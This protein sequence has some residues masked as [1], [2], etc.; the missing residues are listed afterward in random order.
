MQPILLALPTILSTAKEVFG[1][2]RELYTYVN[3]L[4]SAAQQDA[5]WTEAQDAHWQQQI[6]D[7]GLEPHW[8]PRN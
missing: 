3:K 5:E 2:G 8:Q 6:R 7:A 4:R 1:V